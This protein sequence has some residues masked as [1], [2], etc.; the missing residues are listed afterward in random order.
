MLGSGVTSTGIVDCAELPLPSV[1]VSVTWNVPAGGK[2]WN[3]SGC[4]ISLVVPSS[5]CHW[6]EAAPNVTASKRTCQCT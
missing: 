6:Y 2:R 4:V 1:T 3:A 5:N